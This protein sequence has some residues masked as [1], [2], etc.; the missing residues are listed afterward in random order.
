MPFATTWLELEEI[1]LSE[2]NQKDKEKFWMVSLF[3]E[4]YHKD[5]L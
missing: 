5:K 4:K 3:Y 2:A 1:I